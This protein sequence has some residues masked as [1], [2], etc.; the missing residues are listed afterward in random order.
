MVVP[1]AVERGATSTGGRKSA[2][3][4][5]VSASDLLH[6]QKHRHLPGPRRT[7]ER[8]TGRHRDTL[9]ASPPDHRARPT[10][11]CADRC[12]GRTSRHARA[13]RRHSADDL[14]QRTGWIRTP[15]LA[16][17]V[18]FGEPERARHQP[19]QHHDRPQR[20]IQEPVSGVVPADQRHA[21]PTT[22]TGKANT[23]TNGASTSWETIMSRRRGGV[24]STGAPSRPLLLPAEPSMG[25]TP[26]IDVLVFGG[27][28]PT[29]SAAAAGRSMP[30]TLTGPRAVPAPPGIDVRARSPAGEHQSARLEQRHRHRPLLGACRPARVCPAASVSDRGA[31]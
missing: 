22:T 7:M 31:G 15:P 2:P 28:R 27:S 24:S 9:G 19:H 23:V 21:C 8:P 13:Q 14:G 1:S 12:A 17:D 26:L 16:A 11:R 10:R 25:H 20:H 30:V 5:A 18:A 29:W 3:A 6:H 4:A